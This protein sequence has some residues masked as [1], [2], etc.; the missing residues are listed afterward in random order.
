[1]ELEL[2]AGCCE[3]IVWLQLEVSRRHIDYHTRVFGYSTPN[4][5]F[6]QGYIE[7]LKDVG[8]ADESVDVIV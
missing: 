2:S 1:V 7:K 4:V 5:E 8:I 3:L 6:R